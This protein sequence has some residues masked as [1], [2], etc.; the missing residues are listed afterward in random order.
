LASGVCNR[1]HTSTGIQEK[2]VG[3]FVRFSPPSGNDALTISNTGEATFASVLV[4]LGNIFTAKS[5]S[6]EAGWASANRTRW[7]W[8]QQPELIA[9]SV[10]AILLP[11]S[12][13]NQ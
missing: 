3:V 12:T 9:G 13:S 1:D 4:L 6:V 11:S 7:Q 5:K 8:Q 10:V 2:V